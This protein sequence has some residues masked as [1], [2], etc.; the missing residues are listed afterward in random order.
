M[1]SRSVTAASSQIEDGVRILVYNFYES[2][3]MIS[4]NK[5]IVAST[6]ALT[7]NRHKEQLSIS[8]SAPPTT[9]GGM[10]TH[11]LRMRMRHSRS[12]PHFRIK[13]NSLNI[14]ISPRN[15]SNIAAHQ[16]ALQA[17]LGK[18]HDLTLGK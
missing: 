18:V 8:P 3:S 1:L 11:E 14:S 6:V 13:R 7:T 4:T 10:R 12:S 15:S 17:D 5:G 9:L 2:F 16:L